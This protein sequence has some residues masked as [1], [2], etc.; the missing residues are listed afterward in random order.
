MTDLIDRGGNMRG[1]ADIIVMPEDG[2]ST[3][4]AGDAQTMSGRS[5]GGNDVITG[6]GSSNPSSPG[7]NIFAGDAVL[8][9]GDAR[10]GSDLLICGAGA[11]NAI[12]GDAQTLSGR[13]AGGKDIIEGSPPRPTVSRASMATA[14]SLPALPAAETIASA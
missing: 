13:A 5:R 9:T 3:P 12:Y 7:L 8:M 6:G 14:T 11:V 1:R 2:N 4:F 10:G